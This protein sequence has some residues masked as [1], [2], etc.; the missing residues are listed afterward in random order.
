MRCYVGMGG[1]RCR[2][3]ELGQGWEIRQEE[4]IGKN[5]RHLCDISGRKC[6]HKCNLFLKN[7]SVSKSH[8]A[9]LGNKK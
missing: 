7:I 2:L 4:L 1:G 5:Y 9:G 8:F 6:N 3:C